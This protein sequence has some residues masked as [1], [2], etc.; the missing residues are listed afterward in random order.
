MKSGR[1]KRARE[2]L[3]LH[4]MSMSI[5]SGVEQEATTMP[6]QR[7]D[8]MEYRSTLRGW[9]IH[10]DGGLGGVLF[11]RDTTKLGCCL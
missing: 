1:S 9:H 2:P 5:Y 10:P 3:L 8:V 11:S 6:R 7:A 4:L